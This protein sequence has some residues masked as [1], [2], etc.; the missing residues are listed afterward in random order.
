VVLGSLFLGATPLQAAE[1][2]FCADLVAQVQSSLPELGHRF[3]P[4]F[5]VDFFAMWQPGRQR[6][7]DSHPIDDRIAIE[8]EC[9]DSGG[10]VA[11]RSLGRLTEGEAGDLWISAHIPADMVTMALT[12]ELGPSFEDLRQAALDAFAEHPSNRTGEARSAINGTYDAVARFDFGPEIATLI[13][14]IERSRAEEEEM[15]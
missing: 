3:G 2:I 5:G 14:A 10:L 6:S 8:I 12:G 9:D 1:P 15:R 7:I 11:F 4:A 13:Y